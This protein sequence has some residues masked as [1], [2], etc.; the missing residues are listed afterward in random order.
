M[1]PNRSSRETRRARIRSLHDRFLLSPLEKFKQFGKLPYKMILHILLAAFSTTLCILFAAYRNPVSFAQRGAFGVL[2]MP[3]GSLPQIDTGYGSPTYDFVTT[4]GFLSHLQ[5]VVASYYSLNEVSPDLY[6]LLDSPADGLRL[7]LELY[8]DVNV[9]DID[10]TR[11]K[12]DRDPDTADFMLT[13]G[14][15]G[16]FNMSNAQGVKSMYLDRMIGA[17]LKFSL[18]STNLLS[19]IP[20]CMEWHVTFIYD[21]SQRGGSIRLFLDVD[22]LFCSHVPSDVSDL[23]NIPTFWIAL[24]AILVAFLSICFSMRRLWKLRSVKKQFPYI[25]WR[26]IIGLMD[27]WIVFAIVSSLMIFISS[28]FL[29]SSLAYEF[30]DDE[31]VALLMGFG[32]LCSWVNLVRYFEFSPKLYIL[33]LTLRRGMPNVLRFVFGV[34]PVFLGYC[35]FGTIVFGAYVHAFESIGSSAVTLFAVLNGDRIWD[36]FADIYNINPAL[37]VISRIYLYTFICLFIYAVLNIFIHIME[38]GFFSAKEDPHPHNRF[39][40][41][42]NRIMSTR[43]SMIAPP[44]PGM[45]MGL[46][47]EDILLRDLQKS[48]RTGNHTYGGTRAGRK[49]VSNDALSQPLMEASPSSEL[50]DGAERGVLRRGGGADDD[51][52]DDVDDNIDVKESER[53]RPLRSSAASVVHDPSKLS[54][55]AALQTLELV[56]MQLRKVHYGKGMSQEDKFNLAMLLNLSQRFCDCRGHSDPASS[57]SS[58]SDTAASST[59]TSSI[60]ATSATGGSSP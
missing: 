11:G 35:I 32:C 19:W 9:R 42:V 52:D 27:M 24:L 46:E 38:E 34:A 31:A 45:E 13:P 1:T 33:I 12:I 28:C 56:Q 53:G 5:F 29:I 2:F 59:A 22:R 18:S 30:G 36:T 49:K 25:P 43:E 26:L 47:A 3:S 16:P 58:L 14:N 7:Q 40:K 48:K 41:V 60:M 20:T 51:D 39:E 54:I 50:H 6:T 37:G 17:K 4:E 55:D 21:F 10:Y 15:M 23:S 57:T 8:R 44:L